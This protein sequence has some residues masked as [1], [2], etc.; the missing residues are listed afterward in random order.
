[1]AVGILRN[2]PC[3]SHTT[4]IFVFFYFLVNF[5]L[6]SENKDTDVRTEYHDFIKNVLNLICQEL[7]DTYIIQRYDLK[8]VQSVKK[9]HS[10]G[11]LKLIW[12]PTPRSCERGFSPYKFIN[13]GSIDVGKRWKE[14]CFVV[15]E[16]CM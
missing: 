2:Q 14:V 9:N 12:Q 4:K 11:V 13:I 3:T 7:I 16:H 10:F 8:R 15:L 6:F 5:K 1:M